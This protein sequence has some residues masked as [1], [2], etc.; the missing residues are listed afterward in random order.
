M[1]LLPLLLIIGFL[2]LFSQNLS[3][4]NACLENYPLH[5][6]VMGSSTAAGTGPSHPDSTWVNRYRRAL[7]VINPAHRV[8]NIARGGYNTYRLMPS[9]FV[10][11]TGLPLPDSTKNITHAISLSPDAIIINLPSNDAALNISAAT[12][13]QNFR[14]MVDSAQLAGIPVWICTTQPR[15]FSSSKIAI[16][17]E[18]RDSILTVFGNRA[19]DFWTGLADTSGLPLTQ[20]DSGD[21][22]HLNDAGHNILFER[23]RGQAVADTAF[24][25]QYGS[26]ES[27]Y[28]WLG[29]INRP[30][31]SGRKVPFSLIR[32][33]VGTTD[34]SGISYELRLTSDN[35]NLTISLSDSLPPL[36]SCQAD[37][38]LLELDLPE[39]G[40]WELEAILIHG[41]QQDT[42]S[43]TL[44]LIGER[45]PIPLDES[46][47]LGDTVTLR[48]L[49]IDTGTF[50]WYISP[51]AD[52]PFY[53]GDGLSMSELSHDTTFWVSLTG[54]RIA[55]R[56]SLQTLD[57]YDRDWNGIMI[58]LI[59]KVDLLLDTLFIPISTTG[60]RRL[61]IYT[62]QG[63]YL[64][65]EQS[66][67]AWQ[68]QDSVAVS[69]TSIGTWIPIPIDAL[70]LQAGDT[71]GLYLH[72]AQSN[73]R[74]RYQAV[75]TP[76]RFENDELS[77]ITGTGISHTF[78]QTYYP[79]MI[80]AAFSYRYEIGPC[81]SVAAPLQVDVTD[82]SFY[83]GNDTSL[84]SGDTLQLTG[85]LADRYLWS[86]GD[87]TTSIT[88]A[89]SQGM[90]D[91][92]TIWLT[93]EVGPNCQ[94]SDTLHITFSAPSS[95][96][97]SEEKGQTRFTYY[98]DI[99][100]FQLHSQP[101]PG[102][103]IWLMDAMGRKIYQWEPQP[104]PAYTYSIP[105][106]PPGIYGLVLSHEVDT[107]LKIWVRN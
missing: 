103:Y 28:E 106:I 59:P 102:S 13:M 82:P 4:A 100:A 72:L 18:T 31:C 55:F 3:S 104:F 79:R 97:Q 7:Q 1:K 91:N 87:T 62:T 44:Q 96:E 52:T 25:V 93:I 58:D 90:N 65:K 75:S 38:L 60:N 8:T 32:T 2:P 6:V 11:P 99:H 33:H 101:K 61:T 78:G 29:M 81:E 89:Q 98:P 86:T 34:T 42:L 63:S 80:N 57:Q 84:M 107:S 73:G 66:P 50:N 76:Q 9:S 88:I 56:D 27:S 10:P 35:H 41:L 77:L 36:E 5:I 70:S 95:L 15:V 92:V 48:A 24:A 69:V 49:P 26:Q 83:L 14:T 16:Q 23:V 40:N 39:E 74:L 105:S 54:E 17:L 51:T 47:C 46:L 30:V 12:Q 19:I 85:P 43:Q 20:Y 53:M 45:A 37:T 21:G 22:V 67:Q 68:L 71:T 94:A 64:G